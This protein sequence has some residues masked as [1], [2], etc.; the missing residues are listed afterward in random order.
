MSPS[1]LVEI[2]MKPWEKSR[3][4][5]W[6]VSLLLFLTCSGSHLIA[7]D[8]GKIMLDPRNSGPVDMADLALLL[9]SHTLFQAFDYSTDEAI[10]LQLGF[11]HEVDGS[12][13]GVL[14]GRQVDAQEGGYLCHK[15]GE[16]RLLVVLRAIGDRWA[17]SFGEHDRS[18][19]TGGSFGYADIDVEGD[20][21]GTSLY[22]PTAIDLSSEPT[23]LLA[24]TLTDRT[25]G[26]TRRNEILIQ[27]SVLANPNGQQSAGGH[28]P[29]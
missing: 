28:A 8:T 12:E 22:L 4:T 3:S 17:L 2:D 19:G 13:N 24:W 5:A 16:H 29:Q 1:K 15:S 11:V 6:L 25:G 21:F 7:E 18:I 27:V 10:C 23:T 26:K 9:P 14:D 20:I